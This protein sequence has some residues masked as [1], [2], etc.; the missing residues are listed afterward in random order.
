MRSKAFQNPL[1][2]KFKE[3]E[4]RSKKGTVTT[5]L[6]LGMSDIGKAV[7]QE[8]S[9]VSSLRNFSFPLEFLMAM[10]NLKPYK[11]FSQ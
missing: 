9:A 1:E 5:A 7:K 8:K 6:R 11:R 2:W 4:E 10:T 3:C